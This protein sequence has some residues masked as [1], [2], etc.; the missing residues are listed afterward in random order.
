MQP[1]AACAYASPRSEVTPFEGVHPEDLE[2]IRF[3]VQKQ[4]SDPHGE[5][6]W[7]PIRY[8][9]QRKDGTYVEVEVSGACSVRARTAPRARACTRADPLCGFPSN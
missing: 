3:F 5:Y 7:K 9:K 1:C 6:A 8:R 4:K 2:Q